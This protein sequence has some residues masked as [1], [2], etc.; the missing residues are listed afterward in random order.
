MPD[1]GINFVLI[2]PIR[3]YWNQILCYIIMKIFKPIFKGVRKPFKL[4]KVYLKQKAGWLGVPKILP[5]RGFGDTTH[6][7]IKGMVIEDKGLS[8]PADKQKVWKNILAMVKRFSS[9]EIPGVK[10]R[11]EFHGM[12]AVAETDDWGFFSFYFNVS[13]VPDDI[14]KRDWHEVHFTLLDE[15]VEGQPRVTAVGEVRI[16]SAQEKRIIV[17]DID[18]TVLI[19]HS[20]TILPKLRLMLFRNALTRAPF[21]GVSA[22]YSALEKGQGSDANVPFFYVSSSEW[23]LYDLLY[24][25]FNHNNIPRGVFM[26]RKLE[27]NIL[28]FWKSGQGDHEHKYDKIR[29]L[30]DLYENHSFIL[31]GDSGQKDPKIYN[32]LAQ[33]YPGR[34][35]T[36]YIRKIGSKPAAYD[37]QHL[38]EKLEKVTTEYLQI[39]NTFEAATHALNKGYITAN[40]FNEQLVEME[41]ETFKI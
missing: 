11:A 19:S 4:L 40:A 22:F 8:K 35:E 23:N 24:D 30:L 26:L 7:Y 9:D 10:L 28:K 29:F 3:L 18:D 25:F 27:H 33:D 31:I 6:V 21:K 13:H 41:E 17:S 14:K 38:N 36:I 37:L 34:I 1:G 16:V 20:T 15:I 12:S 5:Y 32:R 39:D 2:L